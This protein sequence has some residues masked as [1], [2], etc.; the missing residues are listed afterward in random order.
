[1]STH[2]T[3]DKGDIGVAKVFADLVAKGYMVLFPATEH[4]AFDLVAYA[5]PDFL[6]VQVKY[7]SARGGAVK[8]AFRSLWADRNGTHTRRW[9]KTAVDL[10]AI[11]CPEVDS[12]F[13]VDPT[14][15]SES[16]TLRIGQTRNGQGVG[17]RDADSHRDLPL[18]RRRACHVD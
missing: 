9:D 3:K 8:V 4:A 17:I 10:V 5:D 18:T 7:R 1:M 16:V 2:H 13:Y 11:Y 14:E 6:R 15:F 12:C